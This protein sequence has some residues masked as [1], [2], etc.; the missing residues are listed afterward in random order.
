MVT[1]LGS[2]CFRKMPVGLCNACASFQRFEVLRGLLFVFVHIDDVLIFSKTREER[3]KHLILV[4]EEFKYYGL[5]L[6]KDKSIFDVDKIKFL[7]HKVNQEGV[8][9]LESK[10]TAIQNFLRPSSMKQLLDF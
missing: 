10:V 6:N 1:P 8:A 7:G 9:P 3:M 5:I 2:Y 4:F